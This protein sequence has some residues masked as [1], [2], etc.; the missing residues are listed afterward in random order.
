MYR[1]EDLRKRT[2]PV[3]PPAYRGEYSPSVREGRIINRV[4][5]NHQ[6]LS[7]PIPDGES[8]ITSLCRGCHGRIYGATSGVRSH[9]FLYDPGPGGDGVCDIGVIPGATGV[10]QALVA[11]PDGTLYGAISEGPEAGRLFRCLTDRD[12]QNEFGYGCGPVEMLGVPV[13]GEGIAGLVLDGRRRRFYGVSRAS[14]K[15]FYYDL[16]DDRSE[17][18]AELDAKGRFSERLV[19]DGAGVVYG[20]RSEGEFFR[21]DPAVDRLEGLGAHLPAL[22]GREMYNRLES[23]VFND[24]DGLIYGGGSADGVLFSL[25]PASGRVRSLGKASAAAGCPALAAGFDGRIYGISGTRSG[26]ARL[27]RYDPDEHSLEDLGLPLAASE[28]FWHGYEF[29]AAC[30][31]SAGE[32]YLGESDRVSHL[33]I[34]FPPVLRR[35]R[36][37]V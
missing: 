28:T 30:T 20:C 15:F 31:G 24:Y 21:Y 13:P 34:Y 19:L 16:Q 25:D 8:A 37:D 6:S 23:A 10:R 4:L 33:F 2:W 7:E 17:V 1:E 22:A 11:A 35:R 18:K 12:F 26:M 9:L 29:S 5:R 14:G 36:A 32:I 27:F 3:K